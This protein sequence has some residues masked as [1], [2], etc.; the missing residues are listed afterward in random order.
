MR[1]AAG[2]IRVDEGHI[3]SDMAGVHGAVLRLLG[4]AEAV[5]PL[6]RQGVG[7]RV[8]VHGSDQ[9]GPRAHEGQTEA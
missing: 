7:Q 6:L 2:H 8:R 3:L 4:D 5:P 1:C 9:R